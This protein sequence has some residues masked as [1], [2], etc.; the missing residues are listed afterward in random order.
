[1]ELAC[2]SGSSASPSSEE[3]GEDNSTGTFWRWSL[4]ITNTV[5]V[6]LL[7]LN[8]HVGKCSK[9]KIVTQTSSSLGCTVCIHIHS[10]ESSEGFL[11]C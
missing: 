7:L 11:G 10:L 2:A 4:A 6:E 9:E 1:M 8:V 3:S 5:W